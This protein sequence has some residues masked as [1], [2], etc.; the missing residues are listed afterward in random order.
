MKKILFVLVALLFTAPAWSAVDITVTVDPEVD[1]CLAVIGYDART[2]PNLPRAFALNIQADN[3]AN[4][5]SVALLSADYDIHPGTIVID[6]Q[7]EVTD[8][9]SPVAP[10]S[11]LP[12]DTLPGLDSNGVT[13]EMASLYAPVGSPVNAPD[14]CGLLVSVTV[15]KECTLTITANVSR[16]GSSGV[17][18]ESP[19]EVVTVNLPAPILME[20]CG[21]EE[22]CLKNT[23]AEYGD[24]VNWQSP[25]C[26]C[27]KKQCRGDINGSSFLGKPVS[28]AD[29]TTFKLAFNQPDSVVEGIA[30]GICADLNHKA[31]LGKRVT[32]ADLTIFKANFNVPEAS[33][34]CCD[35]NQDCVLEA[36]DIYNFWTN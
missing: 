28:L 19:D 33:V 26:W 30:D 29:L 24:W 10:E 14:P 34:P 13:I 35:D 36:T 5:V 23:A 22:E 12:S 27:Y 4:I 20:G 2:E 6:T 7:G 3:D 18:M 17:V 25:D 9:G 31:F 21:V 16:A 15:D 1:K 11:D 32:L 8:Y